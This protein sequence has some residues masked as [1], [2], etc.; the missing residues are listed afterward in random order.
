MSKAAA[1]EDHAI[2]VDSRAVIVPPHR[3]PSGTAADFEPRA[4]TRVVEDRRRLL[5]VQLAAPL[6]RIAQAVRAFHRVI[7]IAARL[8][9]NLGERTGAPATGGAVHGGQRRA[10][11]D[12]HRTF[13]LPGCDRRRAVDV[14]RLSQELAVSG[15]AE[16]EIMMLR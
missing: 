11:V 14:W 16:I 4:L 9:A 12:Q 15:I 10:F 13:G 3:S 5:A 7:R 6:L 2:S 1:G 8:H